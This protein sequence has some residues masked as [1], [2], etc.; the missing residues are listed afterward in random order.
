VTVTT[1]NRVILITAS[2]AMAVSFLIGLF[3]FAMTFFIAVPL[4]D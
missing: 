4:W 2:I 1:K 3:Y